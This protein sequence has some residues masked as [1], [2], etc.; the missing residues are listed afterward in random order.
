MPDLATTLSVV[1]AV[2]VGATIIR[3]L[4]RGVR[5]LTGHGSSFSVA[6]FFMEDRVFDHRDL[7]WL[8][9]PP[10]VGGMLVVFWPGTNGGIAGASGFFAAFLDVWP[11]YQ[12]PAVL[13]EEGLYEFW[14][15]L[16]IL[17]AV[18]VGMSAAVTYVGFIIVDRIVPVAGTLSRARVWQQF[19]EGLSANAIYGPAKYVV[20]TLL[21][22]GGLYFNREL[23]RVEK[24]AHL[25]KAA[26]EKP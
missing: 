22:L 24:A 2:V 20:A 8:V 26:H 19:L 18:F 5:R 9:F 6:G 23:V 21:V 12:Y 15:K 16:K 17:S 13:L 11:I 3:L 1:L 4:H 25:K 10:L 7:L 14:P